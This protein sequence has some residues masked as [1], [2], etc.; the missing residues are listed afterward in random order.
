MC[1]L[2]SY[3]YGKLLSWGYLNTFPLHCM[4]HIGDEMI[5]RSIVNWLFCQEYHVIRIEERLRFA[6][7]STHAPFRAI[8]P[9]G[10][11]QSFTCN[12]SSTTTLVVLLFVS[13]HNER[14]IRC[15][16]ALSFLEDKRNLSTR[17]DDIQIRTYTVRRLR[18]F[19]RR[20][21]STARPP[22]VDI[23]ARKPWHFARLRVL[24]W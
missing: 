8:T 22:L 10:I 19:A 11:P 23:R 21:A 3:Y 9:N 18:P 13:Y 7:E 20:R 1:R 16:N 15:A 12:K 4:L 5:K 14:D 2:H 17:F 6:I 24:G